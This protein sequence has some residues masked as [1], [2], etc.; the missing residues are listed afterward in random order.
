MGSEL[1]VRKSVANKTLLTVIPVFGRLYHAS[2]GLA[3]V[4]LHLGNCPAARNRLHPVGSQWELVHILIIVVGNVL[5][6][7]AASLLSSVVI[8]TNRK[9]RRGSIPIDITLLI[10]YLL[11]T[12]HFL[13]CIDY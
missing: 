10:V 9:S 3:V 11:Y 2:R 8:D 6:I 7:L 5:A 1:K 4:E 12:N 13:P